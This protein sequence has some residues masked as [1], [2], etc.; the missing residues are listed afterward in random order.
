MIGDQYLQARA[1][2]GTAL[3]SLSSLA[4]GLHAGREVL[5]M[6]HD[7]RGELRE[8]F[9]FVVAG[10]E[11]S[12]K[13]SLVNA[14]FGQEII[15][16]DAPPPGDKIHVFKYGASPQEVPV[17]DQFVEH[18]RPETLLRDFN[19]VDT[20]A[21]SV[22]THQHLAVV[23]QIVPDADLVLF[24]FS[25]TNPWSNSSREFLAHLGANPPKN[26]LFILQQC[27]LRDSLEVEAV[28]AHL[29]QVIREKFPGEH[30]VFPVSA[31][32]AMLSKTTGA[33]KEGLFQQSNFGALESYIT[34]VAIHSPGRVSVLRSSCECAQA[35]LADLAEQTRGAHSAIKKDLEILSELA[36]DL[37]EDRSQAV[38]HAGG[39]PWAVAESYE[40]LGK[41]GEEIVME[42]T[43]PADQQPPPPLDAKFEESIVGQ[44][45]HALEWMEA[46][47]LQ[48]WPRFD[49][50]MHQRFPPGNMAEQPPDLIGERAQLLQHLELLIGEKKSPEHF[51]NVAPELFAGI[52]EWLQVPAGE[53]GSGGLRTLAAPLAKLAF[54]DFHHALGAAIVM[55]GKFNAIGKNAR[56]AAQF[57]AEMG[58]KRE[59]L[60]A[61]VEG[62]LR[63][64]AELFHREVLAACEPM[65]SFCAKQMM[66]YEPR[67]ALAKQMDDTLRKTA[68]TLGIAS[69]PPPVPVAE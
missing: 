47:M 31:K 49:E 6:L 14:L 2:L 69:R 46:G 60:L 22:I 58:Y 38:R 16:A 18:H 54:A 41:R 36:A 59:E 51:R 11:R 23:D 20:P 12:G 68:A 35:I 32:K 42:K 66:I 52:A 7:L 62:H 27:D 45:R 19:I 53:V 67:L 29:E 13:S 44:I 17:Y 3:F 48:T 57:R 25:I 5:Q 28:A 50:L 63:R 26:T 24:V 39:V 55:K 43:K 64:A 8:P 37:D 56:I 65:Q 9:L 34:D 30:R 61:V 1:Q 4:H 21:S 15:P 40:R 10:E 33:D